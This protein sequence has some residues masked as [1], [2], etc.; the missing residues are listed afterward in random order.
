[1]LSSLS[2][3]IVPRVR[4]L[5]LKRM[6]HRFFGRE[7]LAGASAIIATAEQEQ[8]ELIAGGIPREKIVLRRNGVDGP[9]VMPE[10]GRF[11]EAL[12]IPAEAKLLLFLGRLSE[13]KSPQLLLQA[14]AKVVASEAPGLP[15][16]HLAYKLAIWDR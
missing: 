2:A 8:S 7:M 9:P 13:K 10:R 12:G 14:F 3:C 4:N 6:Y 5:W 15:P 1:M 11:R 16:V